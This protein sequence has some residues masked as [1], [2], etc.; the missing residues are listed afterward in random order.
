MGPWLLLDGLNVQLRR[1]M[2]ARQQLAE[3]RNE[4]FVGGGDRHRSE[5]M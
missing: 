1:A 3:G 5:R 2:D 4:G